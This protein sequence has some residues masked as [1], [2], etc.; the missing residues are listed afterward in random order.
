[1]E[2]SVNCLVAPSPE[3]SFRDVNTEFV[4]I[5]EEEIETN[6]HSQFTLMACCLNKDVNITEVAEGKHQLQV[7]GGNHSRIALQSLHLKYPDRPAYQKCTIK[8]YIN[9]TDQECLRVGYIHNKIH[10]FALTSSFEDLTKL[11]QRHLKFKGEKPGKQITKRWKNSLVEILG[12]D[13]EKVG[14]FSRCQY[15]L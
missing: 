1:M 8:L 2:V 3:H 14:F 6:P 15:L 13:K 9:L 4:R 5:L 11:F 12:L 10:N 7:I